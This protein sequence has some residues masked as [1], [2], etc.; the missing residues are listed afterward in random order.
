MSDAD[1]EDLAK[2]VGVL[3]KLAAPLGRDAT[4][5][6]PRCGWPMREDKY[7]CPGCADA[8]GK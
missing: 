6:C 2:S 3:K 5:L 4:A 7:F 8:L 1:I